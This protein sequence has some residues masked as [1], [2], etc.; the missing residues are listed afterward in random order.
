MRRY[1]WKWKNGLCALLCALLVLWAV[2]AGPA[3]AVGFF[4]DVPPTA[5]YASDVLALVDKGVIQGTGQNQFSPN[6]PLS[7]GAFVTMICKT[8]LSPQE[9]QA[10]AFQGGFSDVPAA[11]WASPAVNWAAESGVVNGRGDGTF[12]PDAPVSRQDMAVMLMNLIHSTG[13]QLPGVNP[14]AEFSDGASISGYARGSVSACQQAGVINGYADG[15]FG[16]HQTASRAEAAAMYARFLDRHGPGRYEVVCKRVNGV[17]VKAVEFD[18]HDFSASIALGYGT[19]TGRESPASFVSRTGAVIAVNAAFFLMDSYVPVGTMV[20]DG[21]VLIVDNQFAP[22]K[23]A[24]VIDGNGDASIQGFATRHQAVLRKADGGESVLE[25]MV[26]NQLPGMAWDSTPV[27]FTR[28]WG[29]SLTFAASDAVV[30]GWDGVVR[31]VLHD[32]D[33]AI[34]AD[35]YVIQR[36]GRPGEG[37][38]GFFELAQPGDTVEVGRYYEGASTQDIRLSIGLG[39]RIVKN[40]AVYGDAGTYAAEGFKDPGITVYDARRSC[41]GIKKDGKVMLLTANTNLRDLGKIL[42]AM[43]CQDAVNCDGGGSTNLYVD[44]RW[45]YGPQSRPLN[46]ML[47]FQ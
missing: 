28:D 9:M 13:R 5:W 45:L 14:P 34:P 12:A 18:P 20:S 11:H 4:Y 19:L 47:V 36:R 32:T 15:S 21:R 26:V 30:V 38:G 24:F 17:A 16:P 25:H 39:P 2:P 37:G 31:E 27:M 22:A 23:S 41:I 1:V 6:A 40:G 43:G 44:G 3:V 29:G 10:Y 42:V 35:G 8:L 33:A 46:Q 7:R